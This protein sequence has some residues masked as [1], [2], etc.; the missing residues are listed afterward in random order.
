MSN[1]NK[2]K[3]NEI[4]LTSTQ[5]RFLL[6]SP[7]ILIISTALV[8]VLFTN[9]L[10]RD[11]GYVIGFI[12]YWLVWCLLIPLKILNRNGVINLLKEERSLFSKSN[13]LSAFIFTL[14]IG[15]TIFLYTPG[16]IFTKPTKLLFIAIPVAIIN[17]VC[18]EIYWRGLFL[19]VFPNNIMFGLILPA[20]GF[21]C[22]HISPQL[23]FPAEI[24]IL[25]FIVSTFFLG[26]SY[27]FITYKTRSIK[28]NILSHSLGGILDLG[29]A[30]APSIFALLNF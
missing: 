23:V 2:E 5:K 6:I 18:E 21:A 10:G 19:K 17:G 25:P 13:W 8:F 4:N 15:I 26:I 14:I 1:S 12:Y 28:W 20:I 27:S 22:W 3:Q 7:L 11:L 29:G 24:G 9:W 30:I 16:R